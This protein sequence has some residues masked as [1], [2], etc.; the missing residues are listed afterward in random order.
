MKYVLIYWM[1]YV[2]N[3][4]TATSSVV[5]A[6]QE[7]CDAAGQVLENRLNG[8]N[9]YRVGWQCIPYGEEKAAS[10]SGRP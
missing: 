8:K 4:A 2:L 6:S 10:D 7:A 5:F 1:I 3:N 9:G